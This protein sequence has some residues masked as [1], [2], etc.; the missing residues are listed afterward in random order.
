MI[1]RYTIFIF[2][3]LFQLQSFADEFILTDSLTF[4]NKTEKIE[5]T[6]ITEKNDNASFESIQK[7]QDWK[8]INHFPITFLGDTKVVWLKT[9]LHNK[10]LK[11]Q[12]I[13][14]ITKGIDSLNAYWSSN[15]KFNS[16]ITGKF[17]PLWERIVPSQF[18]V[19][20]I[21]L[22]ANNATTVYL[23]IYSQGYPLSLP[24][25]K[26]L[27]VRQ[28]NK[29]IRYG[30]LGYNIYWGGLFLM[31]LFSVI[32][33]AFFRERLYLYYLFCLIISLT[34]AAIY[35]DY[36]YLIFQKSPEFFRN[37]NVFAV[38]TTL[39][40][41]FYLLFAEQY[42]NVVTN[43][44]TWIIKISRMVMIILIFLLIAL[45][46]LEK[47]LFDFRVFFYPLFG[48]NTLIM[49]YHLLSSIKKKYSPSWYFL[50]ATTPVAV[51][52]MLE[53]TS[54]W[55]EIPIQTMHDYYYVGTFIEMFFLTIGI[56]YRFRMERTEAKLLQQE[57]FVTEIKTQD[58]ERGRI[59][60]D[61]HDNIGASIVGIQYQLDEFADKYF[62]DNSTPTDFQKTLASLAQTYKDVRG[63]S[64]DLTP[65][66]L[67]GM[68][69]YE[70]LQQ[71]YGFMTKPVFKLSFPTEKTD[72]EPFIEL[73]L[74]KIINEAVTNILK[75][76]KSTE[77]GIDISQEKDFVKLR[78]DDNGIG[79]DMETYKTGTGLNNLKFRAESQL[80][81]TLTV[82]SS[83]GNG[84]IILVKFS[85]KY[86]K[87]K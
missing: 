40:N 72:L 6:F 62:P 54:E 13:N 24:Y 80:N 45:L 63:L 84:T 75:Y 15:Y 68:G 19:I 85:T 32:L 10:T 78:I 65:Q 83:P 69:L 67:V 55:N 74:Y 5:W 81:G 17:V 21:E 16:I 22:V 82:E 41:I 11:N 50:I 43:K 47:E 3:F 56:V 35:N 87:K 2:A 42:L 25:L 52:S 57:Q 60:K 76:A 26:V 12:A 30:E 31:L 8:A 51:V 77:V 66:I 59:A 71:K 28:A 73:T 33:Y 20:P 38:L 53:I 79:F 29:F 86:P 14:I 48:I 64:H 27:D 37:K 61:L 23:R 18:L 36:F 39:V 34:M 49:Y 4:G 46:I 70:Q 44:K 58:R 1:K 9:T 7:N